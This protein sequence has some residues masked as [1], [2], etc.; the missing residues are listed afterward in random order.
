MHTRARHNI[1]P[2]YFAAQIIYMKA[3][4]L[5]SPRLQKQHVELQSSIKLTFSPYPSKHM[6]LN[7]SR[8]GACNILT[9]PYFA[10]TYLLLFYK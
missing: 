6:H 5:R 3:K 7:W 9:F 10:R 2:V 4:A 1:G 8:S